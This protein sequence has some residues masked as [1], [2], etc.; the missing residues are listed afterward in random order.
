MTDPYIQNIG[1]ITE[2]VLVFGGPYSNL[3]AT[4]ALLTKARA[5]GIK[6]SNIF[7]TGDVVAYAGDPAATT[8]AIMQSGMQVLMGNCEESFGLEGDDCGCGF[9]EGSACDLLSRQWYAHANTELTPVHRAW[10]RELPRQIRF[11]MADQNITLIHGGLDDISRWIFRSTPADIKRQEIAAIEQVSPTD[12]VIGGHSSLPFIDDLGDRL[13][14]NAGVI[15][16]PANDGSPQTWFTVFSPKTGGVQI[17]LQALS[18]EHNQA[19]ARMRNLN[20]AGAYADTLISGIWP[21]MDVLNAEERDQL[22]L[23]IHPHSTQWPTQ[24]RSAAE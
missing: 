2:P 22:G 24:V 20:L 23:A 8:D 21:N 3:Q 14:V 10:M 12:I 18:Y 13:W 5:L 4:E 9:D 1:E 11:K 15:G 6:S 17:E 19:A 7:C 16:M